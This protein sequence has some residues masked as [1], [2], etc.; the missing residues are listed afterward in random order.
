MK[1]VALTQ[2]SRTNVWQRWLEQ[3]HKLRLHNAA[4]QIHFWIG[5]IAAMY[6]AFMSVTGSIL[7]FRN[8][9]SRWTSLEQLVK[10]HSNLLAGSTGRFIN[11]IGG[12]CLTA[13]CVTG[14][15]AWWPGVKY[16]RR[17]L[18]VGW[19]TNFSRITWDLH[20]A[21]G[22]WSFFFVLL[23]GVSGIYFAF[24]DL[25]AALLFL[26][27]SDKALLWL[28]ELHFGRFGWFAEA[29]WAVLGLVP[30]T[31]ALTGTFI[32]CRRVIFKKPS[33]PYRS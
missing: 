9:L 17:S 25:F 22:F 31:L 2:G 19:G 16:W 7:V 8:E 21:L 14:I 33:N 20:S 30:A 1:T 11:G 27:P 3:P 5:A 15:I 26:D 24:P 12:V 10:L 29:L 28:A 18:T 4:F 32:C 6:L 23:W 13:L